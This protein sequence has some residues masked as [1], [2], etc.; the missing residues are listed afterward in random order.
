M[1]AVNASMKELNLSGWGPND[2]ASSDA[3][4]LQALAPGLGDNG[5]LTSL[6]ISDNNLTIYGRD[7]SGKPRE[8]V[9]GLVI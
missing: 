4:F 3:A 1:L 6:D 7:M 9:F 5:A 8:H 2:R